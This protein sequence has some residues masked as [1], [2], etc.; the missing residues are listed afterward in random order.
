MARITV[1]AGMIRYK[2]TKLT[3]AA[4]VLFAVLLTGCAGNGE[5]AVN[6]K[7]GGIQEQ[8]DAAIGQENTGDRLTITNYHFLISDAF[9]EAF[10]EKYP[11]VELEIT[12]Y[13]GGNGSG[14]AQYS[15]EHGDIPDIYISTQ[16]F[17]RESQQKYLLDLSNYDFVN[18]YSENLLAAQDVNGAIYLLPC[19]Y[20]IIGIN[21]NKTILEEHGWK[22]PK[23]FQELVALAEQ[24]EASG[25]QAMG[26]GMNLDGYSFSYFFNLGNTVYFSTPEGAEWKEGF[27][28]GEKKAVGNAGLKETADYFN[29]WV[30]AGLITQENMDRVRFM[31]GDSVFYLGL[32]INEYEWT[33]EEG[34]TYEFGIMPW[35]GEDAADNMLTRSV[36]KYVGLNRSLAEP[37]NEKK[38]EAALQFMDFLSTLEGQQAL[39]A[40]VNDIPTLHDNVIVEGSPY[41]EIVDMIS[42]G[43]TV[44]LVY[45]GWEKRLVPIAQEIRRLITGETDAAG[46][47]AAFDHVNESLL[48]GTSDDV[49]GTATQTLSLEKTA[50]LV[51]SAEGIAVGA[52]CALISLNGKNSS[53]WGNRYGL[54]WYLYEGEIDSGMVNMIRPASS[55]ISVLELTGAQIKTM[56]DAGFDADDSGQPYEYRLFTADGMSLEDGTVYRLAV[57]SGELTK[58]QQERAVKTEISPAQAIQDYVR[59][60]ETVSEDNISWDADLMLQN[61]QNPDKDMSGRQ[62]EAG[63]GYDKKEPPVGWELT[64]TSEDWGLGFGEAGMQPTGNASAQDLAW[65]DAYY[66]GEDREKVI[67]LTFDCGYENGN[68]EPILDA[69]KK[70]DVQATFFVVGHY[71]E[72]APDLVRR[73]VKEGHTVGNHTYHHLDMSMIS[74]QTTF[75][76]EMEDV[77]TLFQEITGTELSPYYRPPQG[78]CNV[79]NLKMAQALGYR[80]I[81]WSLAYVDWDTDKQPSHEEAFDKLTTRVHPGAVVL[82]HNTSQTNGEILDELLTKWEKM[83]YTFRPLSD[84]TG[85]G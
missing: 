65:Y 79:E 85:A 59:M 25:L 3:C 18:E 8:A 69:L 52:D 47:L 71:L 6:E 42:G 56:R 55:S 73:M 53:Q 78:K 64:L 41:W 11:D 7:Q 68:T 24:I 32:G 16:N 62:E 21:Y 31:E 39:L 66:V 23:D 43:R 67:Y 2:I 27:P 36:S 50:E 46:M 28:K 17:S 77:E 12:S 26:N 54:G 48:S 51:A 1:D 5:T 81:F 20:Q 22:V 38:L 19:G 29:K 84:L 40:N 10:H 63:Q 14:Y 37:G 4:G 13:A 61:R 30:N 34:K 57:S 49:Y 60:L 74:D 76:E 80:T 15:L 33:T 45:V 82:L 9:L 75:R 58:E 70:H 35:L 83:G 72:S 44:P